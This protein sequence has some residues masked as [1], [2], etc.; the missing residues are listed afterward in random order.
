ML[1]LPVFK[2]SKFRNEEGRGEGNLKK[3]KAKKKSKKIFLKG[4]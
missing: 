1:G 4:S 2:S 3:V